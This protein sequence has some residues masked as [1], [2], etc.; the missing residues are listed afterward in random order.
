MRLSRNVFK[1][2]LL[3]KELRDGIVIKGKL[4]NEVVVFREYG[5]LFS[6]HLIKGHKTGYFLDHRDNRRIVGS[7]AQNKNVLDVFSYAGGFSVHALA[8]EA[9]SVISVDISKQALQLAKENASLN[10]NFKNHNCLAGD[11]FEIM[12]RLIKDKK[13][14]NLIVVDPPSFAKRADEIPSAKN[15]YKRLINLALR[16]ASKQAILVMASCTSRISS[17]E[18]FEIIETSVLQAI[19]NK[20]MGISSYK[21]LNKTFHDIDHPVT[22]PEGSYLKTIYVELNGG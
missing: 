14:F 11:A 21:I 5:V 8:G 22:F 20:H 18:F 16:L 6:A 12:N 1:S 19:R 2:P 3:H 17:D 10:G 4:E 13:K 15:S 7:Y 9:Q